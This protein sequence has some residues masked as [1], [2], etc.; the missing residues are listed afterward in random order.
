MD[1]TGRNGQEA[2][3]LIETQTTAEEAGYEDEAGCEDDPHPVQD[4]FQI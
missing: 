4:E 2:E 3:T 1:R